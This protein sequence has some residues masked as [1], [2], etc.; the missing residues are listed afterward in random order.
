MEKTHNSIESTARP[1]L[2]T[3]DWLTSLVGIDTVSAHSN[4]GLIETVRDHL[5][6]QGIRCDLTYDASRGKANLFA[7]IGGGAAPGIVLSGHTDVVPVVG[8][9]WDTDPFAAVEKNGRIYGRGSADMKGFIAA[10]IANAP[11]FANANLPGPIHFALSYDEEV[12]CFGA[13]ELLADLKERGIRAAACIVG[14][15]TG[16]QPIVAHKG[17]H[18]FSCCVRGKEAHS[19]LPNLGVNAIEYAA[20]LVLLVRSMAQEF[21]ETETRDFGFPVPYT[22]LQ[23]TIMNGGTGQNII[24]KQCD[25]LVDVRTLPMTSFESIYQRIQNEGLAIAKRM[26]AIDPNTGVDFEFV[27]SIPAFSVDEQSEL[28]KLAKRLA[29]S[30]RFERVSFGTEAGLFARAGIPTVVIGPG[31]IDEAHRPNES[32]SLEQLAQ[33]EKFLQRLAHPSSFSL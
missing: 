22:T 32:V 16:M 5:Q 21:A 20:E 30:D 11:Y 18:R 6:G 12:G 9:A 33:A 28:V 17:T 4:L 3:L 29:R 31:A 8:Q 14:E 23:T 19:A 25:L 2:A 24:P 27:C 1:S 15:P 26:Q 10:C 13:V 7:T